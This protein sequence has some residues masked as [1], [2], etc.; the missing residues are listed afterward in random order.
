LLSNVCKVI[1]FHLCFNCCMYFDFNCNELSWCNLIPDLFYFHTNNWNNS[2]DSTALHQNMTRK[3]RTLVD[4]YDSILT[5]I[6]KMQEHRWSFFVYLSVVRNAKS[7][8]IPSSVHWRLNLLFIL[9][10]KLHLSY[11]QPC[12]LCSQVWHGWNELWR[13]GVISVSE[14]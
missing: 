11:V 8:W 1:Q 5:L 10:L 13:I 12:L 4:E 9:Y 14:I 3:L 2:N 6:T 7:C